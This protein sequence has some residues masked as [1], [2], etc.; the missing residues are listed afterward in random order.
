M[1]ALGHRDPRM[2]ARYTHVSLE[3]LRGAMGRL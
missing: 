2:S 1:A 3:T